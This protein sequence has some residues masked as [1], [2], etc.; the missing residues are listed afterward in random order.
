MRF[1]PKSSKGWRSEDRA[2]RFHR[3]GDD[4]LHAQI[5]AIDA[6]IGAIHAQIGAIDAQIGAIHA[7]I[8]AIDAQIGRLRP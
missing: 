7:Q 4:A 3:R 8:G 5:G 6:K 2:R 1:A